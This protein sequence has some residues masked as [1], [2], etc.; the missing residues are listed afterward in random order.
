MPHIHA[1]SKSGCV[2]CDAS[3]RTINKAI[4]NGAI[5]PSSVTVHMIDGTEPRAGKI[6]PDIE[7]IRIEDPK[8]QETLKNSLRDRLGAQAPAFIVKYGSGAEAMAWNDFRP[9]KLEKAIALVSSSSAVVM[10]SA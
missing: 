1:Y 2:K 5:A 7:V 10:A 3:M 4:E 8:E 9:D 6:H